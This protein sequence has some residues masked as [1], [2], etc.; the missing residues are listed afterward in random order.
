MKWPIP[1]IPAKA[2]LPQ[3]DYK[4]W[5]II[6]LVM[7]SAGALLALFPG[8]A[9]SYGQTF[10]YG[11]LPATLLW[12]CFFGLAFHRYEKSVNAALLWNEE[13]ERTKL[14]WQRWSRKQQIVVANVALTP[15]KSG[16]LALLG[17]P[18]DI[19]AY[20]EKPRHLYA[21]LP[22]LDERLE[23][24]D[25]EMEKQYPGYRYQLSKIVIQH[26]GKYQSPVIDYAVYTR[27]DLF[28]EYSER[29]EAFCAEDRDEFEGLEL[30][31]CLQDW[32]DGQVESYS[33][34]ITAQLI[35]SSHFASKNAVP[36]IAGVGR[37]MT[38]DS[39]TGALDMLVEYNRLEKESIHYLWLMDMEADDRICLMQY[40]TL[41]KWPLP[42][43]HPLL[44]LG[45]SFGPSGPLM[46]PVAVSLLVDAAKHTGEMQLLISRHAKNRYSLCLV[47]GGLF[48]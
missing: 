6:L 1:E 7:A 48:L 21:K 14:H 47:T 30:L 4:R 25:R 3:P 42:P 38:S 17:K 26:K 45:H 35:T 41:K 31:L 39:I 19:P 28:P 32:A 33:E 9:T 37:S 34:F 10:L 40:A 18:A 43:G 24:I 16:I 27:W 46:F 8:K 36:V 11:I 22:G 20:P 2:V 13:T 15:E 5:G 29:T 44:L 23:F 12:I